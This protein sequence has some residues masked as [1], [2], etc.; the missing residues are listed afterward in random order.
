MFETTDIK[1][2]KKGKCV[3][4]VCEDK[5]DTRTKFNN[6]KYFGCTQ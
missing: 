1:S 6:H 4:A 5:F 3:C 2:F